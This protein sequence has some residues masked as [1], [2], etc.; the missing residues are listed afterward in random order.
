MAG[1]RAA[2]LRPAVGIPP[3][4]SALE[5]G[6]EGG[7]VEGSSPLH[8]PNKGGARASPLFSVNKGVDRLTTFVDRSTGQVDQL[9][10]QLVSS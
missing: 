1:R 3:A 9:T 6:E 4:G 8:G 7:A 5:G 10:G 2:T